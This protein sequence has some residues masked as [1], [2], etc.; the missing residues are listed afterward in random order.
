MV[1]FLASN[2]T[3]CPY[4]V[5]LWPLNGGRDI[6][7]IVASMRKFK[8][9]ARMTLMED[10]VAIEDIDTIYECSNAAMIN[11]TSLTAVQPQQRRSARPGTR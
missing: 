3:F 10:I 6:S 11:T 7:S 2:S 4:T 8:E 9:L 1:F 5:W